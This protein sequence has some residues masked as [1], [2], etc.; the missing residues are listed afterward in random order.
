MVAAIEGN[1]SWLITGASGQLGK[2]LIE[3]LEERGAFYTGLTKGDLDISSPVTK[4]KIINLN[5]SVIV[6]CAAYTLVDQAESERALAAKVNVSGAK[7]VALAAKELGVPLI[8]ISTDYVFSGQ[9]NTPWK[10]TDKTEPVSQ[11][12]RT[13]LEGEK[14]IQDIYPEHSLILR[15]AWLYGPFGKNF[16]KTILKKALSTKD[17]LRVVD[18]QIGQPTSTLD[19]ARQTYE[20]V[21]NGVPAGVYHATNSGEATWY[22]FAQ[23]ILSL[24]GEPTSRIRPIQS[25]EYQTPAKRPSY[26]VLDH[27]EW[28]NTT[29]PAMDNWKLALERVFPLIMRETKKELNLD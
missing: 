26:S 13:K 9:R 6:N 28:Q 4:E 23:E 17:E 18:D 12:G 22:E 25:S 15:T 10:T 5:P 20:A 1:M 3:H 21:T 24:S 14:C 11:Y 8:H 19:L 2:S 16:A 27:A 7:H 29:V